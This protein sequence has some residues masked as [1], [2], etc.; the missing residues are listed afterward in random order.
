MTGR[1]AEQL[2][3]QQDEQPGGLLRPFK[4]SSDW[5]QGKV[6]V[7]LGPLRM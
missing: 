6:G 4:L 7:K 2:P 3:V 1:I 5:V